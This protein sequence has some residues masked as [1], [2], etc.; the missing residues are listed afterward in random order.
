MNKPKPIQ[1]TI[2]TPCTKSWDEM[3]SNAGGRFCDQCSKTVID[4]TTWS[5]SALYNFF[6]KKPQHVCG[7]F[8]NTQLHRPI[9]IPHQPHS[10]LY[11]MTIAMGLTLLFTQTPQLLAQSRPPETVRVDSNKKA[12]NAG[13]PYE[14]PNSD[15]WAYRSPAY[16]ENN[17][18]EATKERPMTLGGP[19]P[20]DLVAL[21]PGVYQ[22]QRGNIIPGSITGVVLDDT[23][24]PLP[25]AVIQLFQNNVLKGGAATDFDG[26]YKLDSIPPGEYDV[27]VTYYGLDTFLTT[28]VVLKSGSH[29]NVNVPM[30]RS[31]NSAYQIEIIS[32]YVK[33]MDPPGTM[34]FSRDQIDHIPH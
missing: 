7:R 14:L 25:S 16:I 10:R 23:K 26:Y 11:R 30:R 22:Q 2:S 15:I 28:G 21:A 33:P 31:N 34:I 19:E 5:D 12:I 9:H 24:Q 3:T 4:F 20:T 32:G 8:V 1:L 18:A 27:M 17:I 13:S 6:A 29:V